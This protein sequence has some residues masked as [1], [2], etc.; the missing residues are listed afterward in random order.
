MAP[1]GQ[2]CPD[3][4]INLTVEPDLKKLD[5]NWTPNKSAPAVVICSI[6]IVPA[7]AWSITHP[8]KYGMVIIIP[9]ENVDKTN[10]P[11]RRYLTG[12]TW[13]KIRWNE[14]DFEDLFFSFSKSVGFEERLEWLIKWFND[15][16]SRRRTCLYPVHP[17]NKTFCMP[18]RY[19]TELML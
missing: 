16:V 17:Q 3:G 11:P 12:S 14:A 10:A 8:V 13:D 4:F 19:P 9:D 1:Y 15:R 5:P 7:T 18:R 6:G 2:P